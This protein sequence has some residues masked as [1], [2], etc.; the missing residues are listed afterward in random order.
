MP[1]VSVIVPN[2]NHAQYLRQR[3]D[4]ILE[5]TFQDFELILLDDCST[6]NSRDV[7][8]SYS[9]DAH[10]THVVI[11]EKNGG[12]PFKQWDKGIELASG[13]WI[14]IAE[15]DDFADT[16]F[17][18]CMME[19]VQDYPKVGFAFTA[20]YFVNG[21]GEIIG[22]SRDGKDDGKEN[23]HVHDSESFIR[24]RIFIRETIDN[25]SECVFKKELYH[26]ENKRLYEWMRLCG[27]WFFYVL[28]VEQT[29]V[30]EVYTPLSYYR[31]HSYNTVISA[32]HEGKTFLEGIEVYKYITRNVL[33]AGRDDYKEMAK[34]WIENE[35]V[36]HY[37]EETNKEIKKRFKKEFPIVVAYYNLLP[38][39]R[40][41]KR[42]LQKK[43]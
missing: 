15:S 12:T 20:T 8:E 1:K 26:P 18:E 10:V 24:N 14:W 25:V 4:S 41:V 40:K 5:Q 38:Q 27:D 22:C 31:K 19:K 30:L 17:L 33:K 23:Y 43:K 9:E 13:E 16:H 34:Y 2:Y 28:L 29:D 35:Q 37:T 42:F 7:I 6:D 11:N 21:A 3:I 39:Y 36:Y 32:E